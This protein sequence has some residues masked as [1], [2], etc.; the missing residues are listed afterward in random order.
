MTNQ[1]TAP[2]NPQFGQGQQQTNPP[3]QEEGSISSS[4][5]TN[6]FS[7]LLDQHPLPGRARSP[8][9]ARNTGFKH[10]YK[11]SSFGDCNDSANE[12]SAGH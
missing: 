11:W 12:A 9:G 1:P 7:L 3:Q 2:L 10:N 4:A 6:P 5:G 8:Y